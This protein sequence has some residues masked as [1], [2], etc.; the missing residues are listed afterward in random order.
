MM[1]WAKLFYRLIQADN[2][3]FHQ[4]LQNAAMTRLE[5]LAVCNQLLFFNTFQSLLSLEIN[6]QIHHHQ[7]ITHNDLIP[8]LITGKLHRGNKFS[9]INQ[10]A[11]FEPRDELPG[12]EPTAHAAI[13]QI[14]NRT[15]RISAR[16][17][18]NPASLYL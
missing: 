3:I 18:Q 7:S 15:S 4:K 10:N 12:C 11:A 17:K 2:M 14:E 6:L 9:L 5:V 16:N 1:S 8:K 13:T